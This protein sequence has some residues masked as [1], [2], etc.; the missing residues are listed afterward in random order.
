MSCVHVII[1]NTSEQ[2]G[3]SGC[4]KSDRQTDRCVAALFWFWSLQFLRPQVEHECKPEQQGQEVIHYLCHPEGRIT[5]PAAPFTLCGIICRLRYSHSYETEPIHGERWDSMGLL[6][7]ILCLHITVQ[8]VWTR[9]APDGWTHVWQAL[10]AS[11][12]HY[13]CQK[14]SWRE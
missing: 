6:S 3:S 13:L 14:H 5:I 7:C 11:A 8:K 4:I 2:T 12:A 10:G 9:E 1:L